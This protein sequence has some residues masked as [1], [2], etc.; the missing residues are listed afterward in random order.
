MQIEKYQL[1]G[2]TLA[3]LLLASFVFE[4]SGNAN[5]IGGMITILWSDLFV[6]FARAW[7]DVRQQEGES[8]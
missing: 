6:E 2:K 4:Y 5:Y 3:T 8:R 1:V 7:R